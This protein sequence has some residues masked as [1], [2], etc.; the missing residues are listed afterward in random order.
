MKLCRLIF[1]LSIFSFSSFISGETKYYDA[2]QFPLIGKITNNTETRYERLPSYLKDKTRPPVWDL[3]KNT[4][5]MAIRFR[6]NSTS[7][8]A[9][10]DLYQDRNMN[11]MTA[12]GIKGLDLYAWTKDHWQFVNTG[13][14]TG[15]SN[16]Q[17]I[18]AN[19]IPEEREYML[20]LP[21]YDGVTSLSIGIDS[22]GFI[23]PPALD[24]PD[25]KHPVICYGTSITQGGCAS[26]PGMSYSNILMRKFNREFINLGFSGNGQLDFEIAEVM[27]KRHD[28]SLF[29]L[30]FVPN[31]NVKQLKEK[32]ADFVRI[33]R[34][35][36]PETPIL[37]VESIIFPH[38]KF[39]QSMQ[40]VVLEKNTALREEYQKLKQKGYKNLYYLSSDNLIGKD[41]EATVDGI[42][43]T[44]LG[45]ERISEKLYQAIKR[46]W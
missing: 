46:I 39:D 12:T 17:T 6:S 30:D 43:L 8:S 5:G 26:R 21:L 20:Y 27:A 37:L 7:I 41:G 42:H 9:K 22:T 16:E 19:M 45:F 31:V 14:P 11:H 2:A 29:V 28:A 1:F 10:W 4:S 36:N 44:D 13:R 38:M 25:T 23:L 15:K 3:G 34:D 18:I 40:Q 33:L 32:T 24:E 35:E